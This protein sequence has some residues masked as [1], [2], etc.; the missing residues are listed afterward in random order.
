MAVTSDDI[1]FTILCSCCDG[2]KADRLIYYMYAFQKAGFALKYRYK[3]QAKGITCR[4]VAAALNRL[5]ALNKVECEGGVLNLAP[6]GYLYYDNVVLTSSEWDKVYKIKQVL[7]SLSLEELF[8]VVVSDILVTDMLGRAGADGLQS[9]RKTIEQ[10]VCNL[11]S[12]Y[13]PENFNDA[14]FVMRQI[15]ES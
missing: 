11:S 15:K 10:A 2:L 6:E 12:A 5:I 1:V 3:V 9:G 7:D 4:E 13:T 14:L 8:L